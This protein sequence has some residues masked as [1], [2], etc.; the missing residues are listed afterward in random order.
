M[1]PEEEIHEIDSCRGP[2]G[3]MCK[4][5]RSAYHLKDYRDVIANLLEGFNTYKRAVSLATEIPGFYEMLDEND[6]KI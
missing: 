4:S 1:T 5:C 2:C 6:I 3:E